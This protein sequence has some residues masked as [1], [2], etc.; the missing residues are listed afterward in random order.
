MT[1]VALKLDAFASDFG[2][3]TIDLFT[4][5]L[6]PKPAKLFEKSIDSTRT[7][8]SEKVVCWD[9]VQTTVGPV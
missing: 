2:I 6:E 7:I 1:G 8:T 5:H 3:D 4:D 9:P